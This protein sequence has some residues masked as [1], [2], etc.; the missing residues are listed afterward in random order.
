MLF[1]SAAK[2]GAP[3]SLTY[4]DQGK[5]SLAEIISAGAEEIPHEIPVH[6]VDVTS[7]SGLPTRA[8]PPA[9]Q[10]G[11]QATVADSY[12]SGACVFDYDGD[13]RPD[14]FLVNA[15]GSGRPA[16]YHNLGNGK[17]EDVTAR[18]GIKF[19]GVGMGC[20]AGDYDNDGHP[21]LAV[22]YTGGV[23]LFHNDG[24]GKFHDVTASTGIHVTGESMGL[25]FVEIGRASCRERVYI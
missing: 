21:D 1:R 10:E 12:G 19:P 11:A 9:I 25:T 7:E 16:L 22:S 18:S 6:F 3:M 5:Y 2:L 4:G 17:F 13:G 15:D 24:G 14:I 23:A 20:T 8:M